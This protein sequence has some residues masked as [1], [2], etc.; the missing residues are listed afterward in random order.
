MFFVGSFWIS[1][2]G[3]LVDVS[4]VQV[5]A[6]QSEGKQRVFFVVL[7]I[8]TDFGSF[9]GSLHRDYPLRQKWE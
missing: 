3:D 7:F 2:P 9:V 1:A 5:L 6:V 8:V 4:Y